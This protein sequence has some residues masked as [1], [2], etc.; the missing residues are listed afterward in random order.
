MPSSL[1]S[2]LGIKVGINLLLW[3]DKPSAHHVAL[4]EQIRGWGFDGVEFPV[5]AMESRDVQILG[6]RCEELG[7]KRSCLVALSADTA[8]PSHP[9]PAFRH[10]ALAQLK[11]CID[12]SRDIGGDILV[13]PFQIY[14]QRSDSGR[15]A[16]LGG[17]YSQGG[18]TRGNDAH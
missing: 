9:D 5:L 10:A 15:I 18:R 14:W 3:T 1:P 4:L 12:K 17:S 2:D 11:Q 7:L 16:A 6:R 13:G 8:D